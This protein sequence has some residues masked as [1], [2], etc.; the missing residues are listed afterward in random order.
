MTIEFKNYRE[1]YADMEVHSAEGGKAGEIAFSNELGKWVFY[2]TDYGLSSSAL[3][4]IADKLDEMG[5]EP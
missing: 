3:R 5:Y 1:E 2:G 4:K